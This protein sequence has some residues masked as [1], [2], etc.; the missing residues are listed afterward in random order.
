MSGA[1][2]YRDGLKFRCTRC[3]NCCTGSPG[4]VLVSDD[5]IEALADHLELPPETFRE[6]YTRRLRSGDVS[7]TEKPSR[8]CVFYAR[9]HGCT[10]HSQRPRQCRTW[11]FW[12]SL[13]HSRERWDEESRSCPG[14][15]RGEHYDAETI[16]ALARNDGTSGSR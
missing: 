4:S 12:N 6:R 1:P 13:V 15:N 8:D 7:L 5:E 10:V 16:T 14:M 9:G 2:W 3:G 11:P